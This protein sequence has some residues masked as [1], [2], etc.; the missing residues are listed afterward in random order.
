MS[1][2]TCLVWEWNIGLATNA[3]LL[4]LSHHITGPVGN[5]TFNLVSKDLIQSISI[6]TIAKA[7]Y[8]TSKLDQA[9]IVSFFEHHITRFWEK[10]IH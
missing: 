4:R 10:R 2:S 6:A 8:S 3:T 1:S 7:R 5:E 9:T